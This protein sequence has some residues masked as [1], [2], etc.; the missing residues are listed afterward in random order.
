M[1]HAAPSSIKKDT[2]TFGTDEQI[3]SRKQMNANERGSEQIKKKTKKS[4]MI[5]FSSLHT[6]AR[7]SGLKRRLAILTVTLQQE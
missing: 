3:S 4:K 6:Q 5:V 7:G 1:V 2:E